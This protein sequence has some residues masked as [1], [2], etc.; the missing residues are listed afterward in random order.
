MDEPRLHIPVKKY[1]GKSVVLS[2]R[3]PVSMLEEIDHIAEKTG[4]PRN[5][6]ITTSLEFALDHL[7]LDQT[8]GEK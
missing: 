6:I 7:T 8:Q 2:V 4:R 3:L 1:S 5:E